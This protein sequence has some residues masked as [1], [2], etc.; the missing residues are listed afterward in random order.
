MIL[1]KVAEIGKKWSTIA[2]LLQ[3]RNEH[4]VKNHFYSLLHISKK[5]KGIDQ[6]MSEAELQKKIKDKID[7]Y[8]NLEKSQKSLLKHEKIS[9]SNISSI[10]SICKIKKKVI[11]NEDHHDSFLPKNNPI[12]SKLMSSSMDENWSKK[13]FFLLDNATSNPICESKIF[14]MEHDFPEDLSKSFSQMDLQDKEFSLSKLRN[15]L[16]MNWSTNS[17]Q[18]Q[19]ESLVKNNNLLYSAKTNEN[20]ELEKSEKLKE[21]PA[22]CGSFRLLNF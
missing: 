10:R 11:F 22:E 3:G 8:K 6:Q 4:S 18:I 19:I 14:K 9:L 2:K 7:Y 12:K 5:K 1:K 20:F 13:V 15:N 17:N 16:N 21:L